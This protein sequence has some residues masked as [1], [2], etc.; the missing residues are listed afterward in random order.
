MK[1]DS[2]SAGS[3]PSALDLWA[4]H[5]CVRCLFPDQ[6]AAGSFVTRQMVEAITHAL[7]GERGLQATAAAP[8]GREPVGLPAAMPASQDPEPDAMAGTSPQPVVPLEDFVAAAQRLRSTQADESAPSFHFV[9]FDW[10]DRVWEPLF[11]I[12]ELRSALRSAA[13]YAHV[14]VAVRGLATLGTESGQS[15]ARRQQAVQQVRDGIDAWVAR[16]AARHASVHIV[17]L[18]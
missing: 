16:A 11:M 18:E 7:V 10:R 4:R 9:A 14:L 6:A 12:H 15:A 17:Y 1:P 8:T 5:H 13:G 3:A 2:V